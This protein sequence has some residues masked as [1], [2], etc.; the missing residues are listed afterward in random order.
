[1][2]A[3]AL[4]PGALTFRW[5][6]IGGDAPAGQ[7][8]QLLNEGQYTTTVDQVALAFTAPANLPPGGVYQQAIEAEL[9][10]VRRRK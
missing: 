4:Q 3:Y 8:R 1:M 5:Y 6:N 10:A 7:I 2:R 9:A